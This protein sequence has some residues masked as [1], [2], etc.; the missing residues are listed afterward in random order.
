MLELIQLPRLS[1]SSLAQ[2]AAVL[3]LEDLLEF[4]L[5]QLTLHCSGTVTILRSMPMS[6]EDLL[7]NLFQLV[8]VLMKSQFPIRA[9]L[10]LLANNS[11]LD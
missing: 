9:K 10:E 8:E 5:T 1:V 2:L 3:L 6:L 4:L 7:F 11:V